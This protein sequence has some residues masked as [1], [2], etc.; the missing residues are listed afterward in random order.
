MAKREKSKQ[1]FSEDEAMAVVRSLVTG[2]S[3]LHKNNIWHRDVKPGNI[4]IKDDKYKVCDY[5]FTKIV[6]CN[7]ASKRNFTKIGTPYYCCP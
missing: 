3:A 4:L 6:E 5:G 1:K 2:L 7:K